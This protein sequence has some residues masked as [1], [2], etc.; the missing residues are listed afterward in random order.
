[1]ISEDVLDI[2][3]KAPSSGVAQTVEKART[4]LTR[5]GLFLYLKAYYIL[6]IYDVI[7][8]YQCLCF[9]DYKKRKMTLANVN[10]L[11]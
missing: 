1:M 4:D 9:S 10:N 7:S 3:I 6:A 8:S 2:L 5:F 11:I